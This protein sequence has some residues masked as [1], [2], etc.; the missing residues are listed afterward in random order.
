MCITITAAHTYSVKCSAERPVLPQIMCAFIDQMHHFHLLDDKT[1][2]CTLNEEANPQ[3]LEEMGDINQQK[4][5]N[6]N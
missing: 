5:R 4:Y 2:R 6:G 3:R 1:L